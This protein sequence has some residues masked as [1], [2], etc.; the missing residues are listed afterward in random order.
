M[1]GPDTEKASLRA[2]MIGKQI[3]LTKAKGGWRT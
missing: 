3:L 1:I 2:E